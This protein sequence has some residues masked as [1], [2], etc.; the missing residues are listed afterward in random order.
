[1]NLPSLQSHFS[2]LPADPIQLPVTYLP[3]NQ[4]QVAILMAP[5]FKL[6]DSKSQDTFKFLNGCKE[7][8]PLFWFDPSKKANKAPVENS[9]SDSKIPSTE[10]SETESWTNDP[11][12]LICVSKSDVESCVRGESEA[13]TDARRAFS[14]PQTPRYSR[15]SSRRSILPSWSEFQHSV[16]HYNTSDP[17]S[18]TKR[19][20]KCE[21]PGCEKVFKRTWNFKDHAR[22]HLG[23]RP[24]EWKH[25]DLTFTQKGNRDKHVL[26]HHT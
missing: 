10:K 18:R 1:M 21:Y 19:L 9:I 11:E 24:Y 3:I 16:V 6:V 22:I 7:P 20:I 15:K 13:F 25:C 17:K 2:T 23:I 4:V 26:K 14:A 5:E 12:T 8:L